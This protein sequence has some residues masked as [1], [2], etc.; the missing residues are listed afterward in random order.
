VPVNTISIC[1][2]GLG[3]PSIALCALMSPHGVT[4]LTAPEIPINTNANANHSRLRSQLMN[5]AI[6]R[7][8]V[9][10]KTENHSAAEYRNTMAVT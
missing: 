10:F 6:C 2:T 7:T 8:S 3:D 1:L 5:C 9:L 4:M